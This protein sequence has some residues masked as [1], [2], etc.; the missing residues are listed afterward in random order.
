MALPG[1]R[2]VRL[3]PACSTVGSLLGIMA[4]HTMSKPKPGLCAIYPTTGLV[5]CPMWMD[6]IAIH[7][8]FAP[9]EPRADHSNL[10]FEWQAVQGQWWDDLGML[11]SHRTVPLL[12]HIPDITL[13]TL[14]RMKGLMWYRG[15]ADPPSFIKPEPPWRRAPVQDPPSHATANP[16][17]LAARPAPPMARNL[18]DGLGYTVHCDILAA[19]NCR[20]TWGR[21]EKI[22]AGGKQVCQHFV[23]VFNVK[24][25]EEQRKDPALPHQCMSKPSKTSGM[26]SALIKKSINSI[27]DGFPD[28]FQDLFDMPC[29][30]IVSGDHLPHTDV[31]TAPDV[32]PPPHRYPSSCHIST[33]VALSPQYRINVLA[34]TAQGEATEE[35]CDEVVLQQEAV[36]VL[37]STARHRGLPAPPGQE[38]QGTLLTQW[39]P[40][41]RDSWVKPNPTHLDPPP[42]PLGAQGLPRPAGRGGRGGRAHF[43][44]TVPIWGWIGGPG[45]AGHPGQ[46]G[47]HLQPP[48]GGARPPR[49]HTPPPNPLL[50]RPRHLPR[51]R[52]RGGH[53]DVEWG[54]RDV[55]REGGFNGR[56]RGGDI[57]AWSYTAPHTSCPRLAATPR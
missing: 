45:R 53:L 21:V 51:H 40:N 10:P 54:V 9:G 6:M 55:G 22:W 32:L 14:H 18:V 57:G 30:I 39:T 28:S 35:R 56:G 34:G 52:A 43:R 31:S 19:E 50:P 2:A 5:H 12:H 26:A 49:V 3:I 29:S 7:K 23:P 11:P 15:I 36:L 20:T 8:Y 47:R 24:P 46:D 13:P 33:F 38:M 16:S 37:V 44:A 42:P 48:R 41:Q 1:L 27:N 25:L 17:V 4:T